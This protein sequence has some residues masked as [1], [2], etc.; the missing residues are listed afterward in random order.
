MRHLFIPKPNLTPLKTLISLRKMNIIYVG[1]SIKKH[2]RGWKR[3][4]FTSLSF[5]KHITLVF[6]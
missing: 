6:L 5:V 3:T 2:P 4:T 1:A